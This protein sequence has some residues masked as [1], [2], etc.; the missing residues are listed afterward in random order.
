M[1]LQGGTPGRADFYKHGSYNVSC[2]MCGRKR[3]YDEMER[4]WQGYFR[5]P[6]HNEP[7][8]PQDFVSSTRDI[9]TVPYAL[10]LVQQFTSLAFE[11]A[12]TVVPN[13][14]VMVNAGL[15]TDLDTE[16]GAQLQTESGNPLSTESV[17]YS[18]PPAAVILPP[19]IEPEAPPWVGRGTDWQPG[20][21]PTY[22]WTFPQGVGFPVNN[23]A[24][25][26]ITT[27][28]LS[29]TTFQTVN[30]V[31]PP[32]IAQVVVTLPNGATATLLVTVTVVSTAQADM[33]TPWLW[34][35][36]NL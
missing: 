18:S 16:A 28:T 3:K 34:F 29:A 5:C 12:A 26:T 6:E 2:S 24:G 19:W 20:P 4:N 14:V 33:T 22:Q 23:G 35:T 25:V 32:S 7:R 11:F 36:L 10:P 27:P 31:E 15:A 17:I 1:G 13:V 30:A 21:G 8:Q 9:M